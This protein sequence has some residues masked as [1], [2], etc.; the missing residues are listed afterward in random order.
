MSKNDNIPEVEQDEITLS[1]DE[2]QPCEVWTR[3]MGYHRP[4]SSF[5]IGKQGEFASRKYFREAKE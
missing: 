3:V 2:R 4:T 1:D 5:N